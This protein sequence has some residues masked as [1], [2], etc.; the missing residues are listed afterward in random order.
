ML[1]VGAKGFAKEVLEV[2]NQN[3]KMKNISFFD[4]VNQDIGDYVFDRFPILK[5][6][7]DVDSFFENNGHEFTIGIGNPRLRLE[8]Y[9]KFSK[10][11]GKFS[12]SISPF[13]RIGSY[14]VSMGDGCN[15]M[16]GTVLTSDIKVGIG[17]LLNLNCTIGHDTE[18]GDFV[19]MS[20]GVNIS[21]HCKINDFANLGTNSTILPNLTI[22]K[23][24]II[25]AGSVVTKNIPDNSLAVGIPAKVI[26]ELQPINFNL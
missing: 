23:N 11:G 15:I 12:S 2:F 5:D 16:T 9:K 26:K 6:F 22:G 18:V 10:I 4:D 1:I 25:G 7:G 8:L 21:G 20:P 17:A 13:A 24:V 19:E 3:N 14:G